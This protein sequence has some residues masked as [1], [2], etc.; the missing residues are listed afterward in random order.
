MFQNIV[1]NISLCYD[2]TELENL[3]NIRQNLVQNFLEEEGNKQANE[4]SLFD[5]QNGGQN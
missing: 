3:E 1:T 4:N 5:D 2:L